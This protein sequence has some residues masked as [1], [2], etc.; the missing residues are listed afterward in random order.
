MKKNISLAI[1]LLCLTLV[2]AA[3]EKYTP[4][5]FDETANGAYFDYGTAAEYDKTLN[6]CDHVVGD[7]D[8]VAL[9]LRVKLLG[10][11]M[12]DARTLAV[13]TDSIEGYPRAN[14]IIPEVVFANNEYVKDV[15]IL[16]VRPKEEELL[17][18]VRI[19]LDGS[20]DIGTAIKDKDAVDLYVIESYTKPVVWES[21]M[22]TLLG[23]W[24]KGKQ[25]FLARHTGDN[26]FY[27]K[28]YDTN[29]SAP[30][31]NDVLELNVSAVNALLAHP[32]SVDGVL[33]DAIALSVTLPILPS[34]DQP[35][36]T[37]PYF[38]DNLKDDLGYF[39][40]EKLTRLGGLLGRIHVQ[41]LIELCGNYSG[42]K[43]ELRT[44]LQ[45]LNDELVPE[46]LDEYNRNAQN[47]L[48]LA[49]YDTLS[50][51]KLRTSGTYPKASQ[52]FWWTAPDS[53]GSA[54]AVKKYFGEYALNKYLF[55]IREV[56]KVE[57]EEPFIA[58]SLF[59]FVLD[60]DTCAWD[61][62]PIGPN[63][64]TGEERLKE[65]YRIIKAANDKRYSK[66]DIPELEL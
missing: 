7:P 15:E 53:L 57:D 17:Y 30:K 1:K 24:S 21:H 23:S 64:L 33:K 40:A 32:D 26:R 49:D 13:K 55:M 59:P 58:A 41:E 47:G 31:Y 12:S 6:F 18:G 8:T 44:A 43:G 63:Q 54:A 52:P 5:L 22:E 45:K 3:C 10:Y 36:Y 27:E 19:Y 34:G 35:N 28:L 39:K 51:V 60:G 25:I 9:T 65:C 37:R 38:W 4:E 14:V 48:T 29:Q 11:L 2:L 50:V 20:G 16:V 56:A 66:F 62:T 61:P 42:G 46:M